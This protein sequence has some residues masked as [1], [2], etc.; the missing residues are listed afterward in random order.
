[1]DAHTERAIEGLKIVL[2]QIADLN[3]PTASSDDIVVT[4][5]I[6]EDIKENADALRNRV[7]ALINHLDPEGTQEEE[8][9]DSMA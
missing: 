9:V 6:L 2:Q 8:D 1:M 3:L 7:L 5:S 4:A